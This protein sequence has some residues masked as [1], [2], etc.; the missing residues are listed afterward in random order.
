MALLL[1]SAHRAPALLPG[2]HDSGHSVID[3]TGDWGG[4]VIWVG[5]LCGVAVTPLVKKSV[6]FRKS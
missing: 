3:D 1:H 2:G 5:I 4:D 6:P